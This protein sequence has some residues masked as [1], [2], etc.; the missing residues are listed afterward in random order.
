MNNLHSI[1]ENTHHVPLP[2]TI[3]D[4]SS[5]SGPYHPKNVCVNNP[6]EQSSRWS[7]N[8]HDQSQ[9]ITLKLDKP[10]VAC[11]ILFGKFHR[12]HVCNLKEFKVYGGLDPN[13][14]KEILHK[15]LT[16]DNK[17]ET[18]PIRYTF[19]DLIFPIQYIKITP[20]ATFGANFNYS[21]WYIEIRGIKEESIMKE[22]YEAYNKYKEMETIRLCL[23]HFR[24]RNMMSVYDALKQERPDIKLEDPLL[25]TLHQKLVIEGEFEI[26]E[27]IIKDANQQ[28]VFQSYVDEA[29]YIPNWRRIYASNNDGNAPCAR[30]GHQIC[31]DV[32]RQKIYLFG[33]WDG[34]Q[35]LA[36]F[37]CYSLKENRWRLISSDTSVQG[38]PSA[39]SCH[40]MCFDPIRKSIYIL[41]RYADIRNN[42]YD[43]SS[44]DNSLYES[45]FYQYFIDLDKWVKLSKN[46]QLDGGPS[47]LCDHQMCVDPISRKLYVFGGRVISSD[48]PP[49]TY[50]GFYV[51]DIDECTWHVISNGT[52]VIP[53]PHAS[54]TIK[55]RA[56]HSMLLDAKSGCIYIFGGQ[57]G[58]E[59]LTD[60]YCYSIEDDKLTEL[61][62]DF[63]KQFGPDAGYTQRAVINADRQ[64]IYIFSG[65]LKNTQQYK[66]Q[67]NTTNYFWVYHIQHNKWEKVYESNNNS[68][69]EE[70]PLARYTHQMIYNPKSNSLFIFGGNPGDTLKPYRRLDD[71][72]ELKLTKPD[73]AQV[74]RK[75]LF[76][77][78]IERLK[79]LLNKSTSKM[80]ALKYLRHYLTPTINYENKEEVQEFKKLC[81]ELC[82]IEVNDTTKGIE[83]DGLLNM[84]FKVNNIRSIDISYFKDRTAVF[85]TLLAF[86]PNHMKEPEGTLIDAVK[87]G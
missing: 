87:I 8:S 73:S 52:Y 81:T 16:D 7:S 9:Y 84:N 11:E 31:L 6:T 28:G 14:L 85:Q 27:Q 37:W 69:G 1:I 29:K 42:S 58:K 56:G 12:S 67:V 71:F 66:K 82:C 39:R 24:Q 44:A 80:E 15:G 76:L 55:S 53:S 57:R 33:G 78:R 51:Y 30:G 40:T 38:G 83:Y 47:L 63:S 18:F 25:S 74:V 36:D 10:A 4:Y 48:T 5:F 68:Q 70:D 13:D 59:T 2:Y 43:V 65:F 50:S 49:Y 3:H 26:V 45:E 34:K 79:E 61:T 20:L 22:V 54:Q 77:L 46:T 60:L 21:I 19:R 75:C 41:G 86:F 32:E 72:W 64:E 23:K 35:E 62:H 17:A